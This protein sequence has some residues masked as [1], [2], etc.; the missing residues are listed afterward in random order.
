M[1]ELCVDVG[2]VCVMNVLSECDGDLMMKFFEMV[3]VCVL[4]FVWWKLNWLDDL[5]DVLD[6]C[7]CEGVCDDVEIE[8]WEWMGGGF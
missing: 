1:N 3:C 7:V 8:V 4:V 5:L 2:V 6:D